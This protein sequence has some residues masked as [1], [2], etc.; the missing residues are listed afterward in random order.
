MRMIVSILD[1]IVIGLGN[2]KSKLSGRDCACYA[3]VLG[4]SVHG[5]SCAPPIA[6]GT[7][8][9]A[10]TSA[11]GSELP[12]HLPHKSL[13]HHLRSSQKLS[14]EKMNL[15]VKLANNRRFQNKETI[16]RRANCRCDL[17]ISHFKASENC[18]SML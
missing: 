15:L 6:S 1:G 11:T 3:A 12:G 5:T 9:L 13:N 7:M 4:T 16:Y 17:M 18:M 14:H 8:R 10:G 2:I